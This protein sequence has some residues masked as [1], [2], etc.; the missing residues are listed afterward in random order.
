MSFH[1]NDELPQVTSQACIHLR[2]KSMYVAGTIGETD[3]PADPGSSA[4]WCNQ[5]QH[6]VGPDSKYVNRQECIEGRDCFKTTY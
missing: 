3:H 4:C 6:F 1:R 2:S 5:T